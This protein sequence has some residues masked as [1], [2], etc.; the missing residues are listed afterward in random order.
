MGRWVVRDAVNRWEVREIEGRRDRLVGAMHRLED[1]EL[2]C[3]LFNSSDIS[4]RPTLEEITER[5][6]RRKVRGR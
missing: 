6:V 1:A 4:Q 2:V 5:P 3:R